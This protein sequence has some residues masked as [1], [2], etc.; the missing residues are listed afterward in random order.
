MPIRINLL[1]A[2]QEAEN[3]RRRDP[4]KR[5]IFGGCALVVLTLG[6]IGITQM[7]VRAA[8]SDLYE[9]TNRLAAIELSSRQVRDIQ[10]NA[11]DAERRLKALDRYTENRFFWGDFLDNLQKIAV[12][13]VR[14]TE[15]RAEQKHLSSD[16]HRFFTTNILV[17]FTPPPAAWK[18]WASDKG[19]PPA[20]L[21]SN[22]LSSITNGPP[23]TTNAIRYSLKI[24]ELSTNLNSGKVM[25]Q[26]DF[27]NAPW[28]SED[29]VVEIRGRDY[30]TP[31]GAAI[32]K[33]ASGLNAHPY[34]KERIAPAHGFRFTERPPQPRPDPQDTINPGGLFVPF[35][36]ELVLNKR[37][38][39]HETL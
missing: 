18:F 15:V 8:R 11:L 7:Q 38:F 23:F 12:D 39:I 4:I 6:W 36:I 5:A 27:S 32:D 20:T 21:V 13:N 33:F 28:A 17:A 30:G 10:M 31:P 26:L 14:L 25:T 3:L 22:L 16:V 37:L 9:Q 24:T 1:A 34:F 29:I 2:E 35:T 19:T